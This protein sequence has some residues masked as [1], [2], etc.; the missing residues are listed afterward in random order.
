[1]LVL[2]K[3]FRLFVKTMTDNEKYSLLYRHSL[4][5]PIPILLY[6]K[7]NT[8]SQFFSAFLKSALNFE[9]FQK[10]DDPHRGCIS[11][12]TVSEKHD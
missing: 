10:T 8:F 12:I 5:Q 4:T 2:L 1:M 6:Q 7:R 11:E 9:Y 3:F